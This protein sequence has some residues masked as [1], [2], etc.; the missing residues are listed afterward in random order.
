M[1]IFIYD[2][3]LSEKKYNNTLS[4]IET[5]ITDLGLN[6]KIVR[7]SLLKNIAS[8]IDDE[9]KRGAKT[10]IAVGSN[11]TLSKV[12]NAIC[13]SNHP[14]ALKVPIFI[15]PVGKENNEIAN[16]LGIL[17]FSDACEILSSRRIEELNTV[18]AN[19]FYFLSEARINTVGTKIE[20][21][22]NYTIEL[23][24]KGN[25]IINNLILN[26]KESPENVICLP[27]DDKIELFIKSKKEKI[28]KSVFSFDK[29][30]IENKFKNLI[31]DKS[32]EIRTPVNIELSSKKIRL[33]IGKNRSF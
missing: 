4:K 11:H 12:L 26:K 23:I 1:N 24:E 8:S 28:I 13:C 20:I 18:K 27:G 31:L 29:I 19:N 14:E 3:F 25:I 2:N 17:N 33:I 6:G 21:D 32:E 7:L 10:L 30:I 5:R 22:K 9:I 16:S 15:I